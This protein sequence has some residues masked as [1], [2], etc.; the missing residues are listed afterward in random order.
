MSD[1][2]T[3]YLSVVERV[4]I[5]LKWNH[6][7]YSNIQ[8]LVAHCTEMDQREAALI[9]AHDEAVQE[10]CDNLGFIED[11]EDLV[12]P[13][14]AGRGSIGSS[15]ESGIR[16]L[17]TERNR[18]REALERIVLASRDVPDQLGSDRNG[19]CSLSDCTC[20]NH[21]AREALAATAPV[22]G[23]STPEPTL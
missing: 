23:L 5:A 22:T 4:I 10:W 16:E 7:S 20:S 14:E 9:A 15:L 1:N 11:M 18:L 12:S 3:A 2:P 8:A 6:G 21:I 17:I 13:K 19:D